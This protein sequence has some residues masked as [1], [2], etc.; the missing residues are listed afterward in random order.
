MTSLTPGQLPQM[1]ERGLKVVIID[2][3]STH[4][5]NT[6]RELIEDQGMHFLLSRSTCYPY[7]TCLGYELLFLPAYSPDYNPIEESFSCCED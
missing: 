5:S 1:D 3:C 2:N 4:K 6:L 7:E